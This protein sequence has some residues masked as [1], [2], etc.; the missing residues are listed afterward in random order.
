MCGYVVGFAVPLV[1]AANFCEGAGQSHH[2][3]IGD[4]QL[5]LAGGFADHDLE[6][7]VAT[8]LLRRPQIQ[9][10]VPVIALRM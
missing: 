7:Q 5:D 4:H 2:M 10:D 9:H 6:R 8:T 3:Q 1:S